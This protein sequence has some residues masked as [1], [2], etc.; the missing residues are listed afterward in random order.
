MHLTDKVM[1]EQN[2]PQFYPDAYTRASNPPVSKR[3]VPGRIQ[4]W[5]TMISFEGEHE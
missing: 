1:E 4:K 3:W 2:G 5:C